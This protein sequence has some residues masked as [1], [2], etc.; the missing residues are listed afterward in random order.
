MTWLIA[1]DPGADG[2]AALFNGLGLVKVISFKY[3]PE[4][5]A[6]LFRMHAA[7]EPALAV[8]ENVHSFS[9]QGVKSMFSFGFARG[10]AEAAT[11]IAGIPLQLVG[12]QEWMQSLGLPK[13]R[14][15]LEAAKRRAARRKDQKE[16]A[17][18]LF[19]QL[20]NQK[21]DIFASVLIGYAA[22]K[23]QPH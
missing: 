13:R 22:A 9:G 8:M 10:Q 4:W 16:M 6:A 2:S 1:I 19:P 14:E 21:G 12:P 23:Q 20:A 18:K 5:P 17:L 15:I 11:T 7:Y 3:T